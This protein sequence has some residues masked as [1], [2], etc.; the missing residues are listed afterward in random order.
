VS[1]TISLIMREYLTRVRT[2]GFIIGTVLFPVFII[3]VMFMPVL[4]SKLN[5]EEATKIAVIDLS[6]QVYPLLVEQNKEDAQGPN[7]KKS[8][9]FERITATSSDIDKSKNE[10]NGKIKNGQI[11]AYIIIPDT[12]MASNSF[13][14]Y[15]KNVSNFA[16][17]A[18]TERAVSDVVVRERL[19]KSGMD[20]E[21]VKKLNRRV[22]AKTFKVGEG[23]E[24]EERSEVAFMATY[25]LVFMLYMALI[26]Y[27]TFVM[28][29]V[30]EDKN[31]K[32]IEV[33]VSSV[34]SHQFMAG[35]IM[36]IG[37]AGLTQFLIWVVCGFIWDLS[38]FLYWDTFCTPRFTRQSAAWSAASPTPRACNG[39]W[40]CC[41][42]LAL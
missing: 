18:K 17:V 30:I 16:V 37:A 6:D 4:F 7:A 40:S 12:V 19:Q 22:H 20:P 9:E 38:S 11:D 10:L 27:G 8:F 1:K 2:K 15:A 25:F 13:D 28:R 26:L 24:K 35:K 32:V 33:V 21:L 41:S 36:G 23:G 42:S 39:Q 31:S 14:M 3:A 5:S 34:K 29:G